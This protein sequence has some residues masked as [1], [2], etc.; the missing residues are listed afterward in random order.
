VSSPE[1]LAK[2]SLVAKVEMEKMTSRSLHPHL[3]HRPRSAEGTVTYQRRSA[4]AKW[5]RCLMRLRPAMSI[6]H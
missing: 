6:N 4:V 1:G 2:D 3:R 5:T